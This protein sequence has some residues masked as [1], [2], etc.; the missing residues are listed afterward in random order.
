MKRIVKYIIFALIAVVFI[1]TFVFLFKKSRPDK[2]QYQEL[3][4]TLA[5]INR[6][7]VVTG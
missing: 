7:T 6:S 4:A 2:I 5:D 3:E 1:G